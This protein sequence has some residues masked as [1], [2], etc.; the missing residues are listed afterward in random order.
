MSTPI[1]WGI[2]GTGKIAH[3]FAAGL[4]ALPD[5]RLV[6]V[7]SR[8]AASAAAFADVHAVPNRHAAYA[9]LAADP[10][11]DVVY[12]ATPH[13]EHHALCLL[14]LRA[15]KAVLCE[16]PFAIN[17]AQAQEVVALARTRGLFLMEAM[18]TRFLPVMARTRQ[19]LAAGAIGEVRM[20][21]AEFGFRA[22][23]DAGSRLFNPALGGGALL[24]VGVYPISLAHMIFGPPTRIS[25][26]AHRGQTGV[27]EQAAIILGY[28]HGQL[29]SLAATV[30]SATPQE[31]VICG[32]DGRI[33][34]P[35]P[36]WRGSSLTLE[37]A[38]QPAQTIACPFAG[39][40][41]AHEAAA[42]QA[43]LRSGETEC[44]SMPLDETVAVMQTLDAVRRKWGLLYPMEAAGGSSD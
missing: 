35:G 41:Y 3:K 15:G 31:A 18:W 40:G 6:A 20:L 2:L 21:L 43:C 38:G 24:D 42:V 27:D 5:A 25:T 13:S 22:T 34:L 14:G 29:A 30:Q 4:A 19:L 32:T 28:E 37:R 1:R 33:R 17:A 36:W 44:A 23:F 7:G 8:A 11:V 10:E 9:D 39:N 16:K 12:I 26:M